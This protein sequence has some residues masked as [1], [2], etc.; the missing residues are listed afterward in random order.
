MGWTLTAERFST[1]RK[2]ARPLR[3]LACI[4]SFHLAFSLVFMSVLAHAFNFGRRCVLLHLSVVS[5]LIAA[6]T[7]CLG[8][9]L[10]SRRVRE[11]LLPKL[12]LSCLPAAGF[13]AL[14]ILYLANYISNARWGN[15]FNY[16]VLAQWQF[17][18]EI[19][20][21]G[22]HILSTQVYVS[23][24]LGL[25]VIF[26]VYLAL[27]KTIFRGLEELFL[28]HR[29]FSLF[30]DRTRS[31]FSLAL[32]TVIVAA[33]TF[34][35]F[36]LARSV[37]EVGHLM[38]EPIIGFFRTET[39]SAEDLNR[40]GLAPKLREQEEHFR[41]AYPRNQQ[42]SRKNVIIII[43]D[44]LRPDHMQVYGYERPT[45]PF[46]SSLYASGRLKRVNFALSTCPHTTCGVLSTMASKNWRSLI[47]ESFKLY[48]LLFD[49]GYQVNF[50]LSGNHNWYALKNSFGKNISY[51]FDGTSST[52]YTANDDR[53]IL[54]GLEPIP[55]FAGKPA[56]FYFH[57]MS[58]HYIGFK[59]DRYRVYNP[60]IIEGTWESLVSDRYDAV[61]KTNNYD[62][63][64]I[65]ADATIR[66]IFQNLNQ[67]G[68]LDDSLV[69]IL[70]DH[71]EGL[72]ERGPDYYSHTL[73]LYQEFI[74][75]PLLVYDTAESKY[76][77]LEF[78]TQTD[79]APT[80]VD[81]LGLSIPPSWQG[82]SLLD[83][84]IK[85]YSYHETRRNKVPIY[86]VFD[87]TEGTV[88]KYIHSG[89]KEDELYE[90]VSDPHERRNLMATTDAGLIARLKM[91]LAEYLSHY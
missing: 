18:A 2:R 19:L 53:V 54:E 48:D 90:L 76:G 84:N 44:S 83:P 15:N 67:K 69:V 59:Q 22:E 4:I 51:F 26:G 63:G 81:R 88:Y 79:V 16:Q 3:S 38:D 35:L 39:E 78:A 71:G 61:T 31:R 14:L 62:N 56:F 46:L 29:P 23:L 91:K 24:V 32:I 12:L 86:A 55:V 8:V 70:S 20:N 34:Y 75:I 72:G 25:V 50:I 58:T 73:T 5:G 77:N 82:R 1:W 49:Q 9:F 42:F 17:N 45:T 37:K 85:E 52:R 64:V 6:I 41:A 66:D 33:F 7:L 11:K 27:S 40:Q 65:Q 43:V 57:L 36:T 28:P 10:F 87:R 89:D 30:R 74:R 68:Y 80:V 21:R 13:A 60:S 47:P